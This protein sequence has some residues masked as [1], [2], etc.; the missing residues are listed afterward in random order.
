MIKKNPLIRGD[1]SIWAVYRP[2]RFIWTGRL[3]HNLW[4]IKFFISKIGARFLH[5]TPIVV[6]VEM[7]GALDCSYFAGNR[8]NLKIPRLKHSKILT[9]PSYLLPPYSTVTLFARFC[10][11][12]T[13]RPSFFAIPTAMSHMGISGR[14]GERSGW[15]VG[16]SI[17]SS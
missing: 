2:V 9:S 17:T 15:D 11:L 3:Y 4:E 10:G 14:N 1:F 7:T 8:N 16:T 6:S 13:S 5:F 12:S